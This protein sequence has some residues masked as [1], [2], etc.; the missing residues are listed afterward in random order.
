[1]T[2]LRR[3]VRSAPGGGGG[4]PWMGVPVRGTL[5]VLAVL[6]LALAPRP[7]A[8][9]QAGSPAGAAETIASSGSMLPAPPIVVLTSY[10]EPFAQAV[11]AAYLRTRPGEDLRFLHK[12]THALIE[13]V[14]SERL[15]R[16]DAVWTSSPIAIAELA[17]AGL[18]ER[19][20]RAGPEAAAGVRPSPPRLHAFAYSRIGI[21]WR[22][23]L[24]RAKGLPPP[25]D[26][27]SL[28]APDYAGLIAMSAPARSGTTLLFVEL[29]LQSL[30]WDE[31]WAYLQ[32]LAGNLAT[33][34]A[35]SFGVPEGLGHGRFPVGIG[36]GF[37]ARTQPTNGEPLAFVA[38]PGDVLLPAGVA[39]L[40]NARNGQGARR[41][42]AFL[43]GE[44]GQAL[45][46]DPQVARIPLAEAREAAPFEE[47]FDYLL[48][49][50]RRD[51]V[52]AL[53]DQ[54]VTYQLDEHRRFWRRWRE[55]EAGLADAGEAAG[56]MTGEAVR[57]ARAL[58][59][60]AYRRATGVPVRAFMAHDPAL[61]RVFSPTAPERLENR[62]FRER[63]LESWH[64]ET[65]ERLAEAG[66]LV[67]QAQRRLAAAV[68]P[69]A[70]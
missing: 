14:T 42:V 17:D 5:A 19:P 30:G 45:L 66:A 34:T 26:L 59:D 50:T 28:L 53:F 11:A 48:A 2:P 40:T 47:R 38:A 35:R 18:L 70:R 68:S 60:Q 23:D 44:E 33:V 63:L 67:E 29:V 65:R 51:V 36:V 57:E 61:V 46:A 55:V 24:M 3:A 64:R 10:P 6:A 25:A 9:Q 13:H 20:A 22:P 37:L 49:S 31:G 69:Q 32:Q 12:S 7:L 16:A 21:M 54:L 62:A 1:M 8:A 43:Q 15:P 39:A 52:V 58:L 4:R 56:E 41:F 27:G